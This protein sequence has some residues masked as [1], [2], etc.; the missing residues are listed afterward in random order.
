VT[1]GRGRD[2]GGDDLDA[3]AAVA[4]FALVAVLALTIALALLQLA[5]FLYQRNVVMAALSDGARLAATAG[6]EPAEGRTAA[7]T[8]LEQG[9]GDG[10]ERIQVSVAERDG[11]IVLTATG[12]LPGY[13]P[14]VPDL[15][16]RL[17]A[18]M[19]DEEDLFTPE[20]SR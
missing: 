11:V 8:L 4:E 19:H 18:R 10:C 5:V 7:C 3:G 17:T 2:A 9:V 20:R 16:V 14:M 6:R 12:R 1:A 13:L 15:P